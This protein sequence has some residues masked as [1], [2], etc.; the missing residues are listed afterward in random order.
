MANKRKPPTPP[1]PQPDPRQLAIARL[2]EQHPRKE[3]WLRI[4]QRIALRFAAAVG[5]TLD[6]AATPS[7]AMAAVQ[8]L[9][10]LQLHLEIVQLL[11]PAE[12]AQAQ[13]QTLQALLAAARPSLHVVRPE[14][15]AEE[16]AAGWQRL[17]AILGG[18]QEPPKA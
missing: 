5:D 16:L 2:L 4:A 1:T 14:R 11:W 6:D 15:T 17:N 8:R 10:E 13:E 18:G 7:S 9:T 12:Y 3:L